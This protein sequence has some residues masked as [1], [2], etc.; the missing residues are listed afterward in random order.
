MPKTNLNSQ[1]SSGFQSSGS[2]SEESG[3]RKRSSRRHIGKMALDET[4]QSQPDGQ[5]SSQ[6]KSDPGELPNDEV[7]RFLEIVTAEKE[8]DD[9]SMPSW[10][11]PVSVFFSV[12]KPE[13]ETEVYVKRL[14]RYAQCSRAAFI[15]G[16]VYL[17]RLE[18]SNSKLAIT[19]YNMHRLLITSLMIA[20]KNLDDRCYSNAHY[21]RVGGI[22]T[23]KEVNRLELQM[24][25]LL[26]YNIYVSQ[27]EYKYF[28]NTLRSGEV[29]DLS[30][31]IARVHDV[32]PREMQRSC[33]IGIPPMASVPKLRIRRVCNS[34]SS[35]LAMPISNLREYCIDEPSDELRV[36]PLCRKEKNLCAR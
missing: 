20:A 24:L 28:V 13:I 18:A 29:P 26:R 4:Q 22:A 7:V 15:I 2:S 1:I 35:N 9:A 31:R 12:T 3:N 23:V 33:G 21:A 19:P 5:S 17:R 14:V 34:R 25:A 27:E 6:A 10:E 16:M 30:A 11:D 36:R 32:F 8:S